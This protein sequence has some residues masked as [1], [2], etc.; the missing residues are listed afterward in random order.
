MEET[1]LFPSG[2][3]TLCGVLYR[4]E[5]Q[6]FWGLV[7][8]PPLFE[9]RKSAQRVMVEAARAFAAAGGAVLRFDYRGCGDSSGDFAAFSCAD[10]RADIGVACRFLAERTPVESLGLL[11]LRLGASLA[12]ETAA[13]HPGLA[14]FLVLWEPLVDGRKY[15]DQELRRKLVNDMVT[16]GRS[17]TTRASLLKD[18]EAGR[19][20]DFD[21]YALSPRL[22]ADLTAIDLLN[23]AWPASNKA[24]LVRISRAGEAGPDLTRLRQTLAAAGT[25]VESIPA[26]EDPFWNLVGL[27]E[28]PTLIRKTRE[29]FLPL[30][31]GPGGEPPPSGR[32]GGARAAESDPRE[33]EACA[34]GCPLDFTVNGETLRGILHEPE[35]AA[36]GPIVVFLHGWAGSRLGPHRM[37]VHFARRLAA[38]GCPSLRFDFRGR[39]DSEGGTMQATIRSMVADAGAAIDAVTDRMPRRKVVLLGICSGCKVAIACAAGDPRV[40]GLALWSAEPMGPMRASAAVGGKS[41]QALRAYGRKLLRLETWRKLLTLSVNVRLVGKAV[42]GREQAGRDEIR[43][44]TRWLAQLRDYTGPALLVYG[45]NDPETRVAKPGY[46]TLFQ[47]ANIPHEVHE[48]AGANHSFYSLARERD[49]MEVTEQWLRLNFKFGADATGRP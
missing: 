35:G 16:F 32:P 21:G 11:G 2:A 20:I 7:M 22:A 8:C 47:K 9:E 31:P 23:S 24:L 44:E 38:A 10:W 13:A 42:A 33:D 29:W 5:R 40:G 34:P 14:R 4:P 36:P 19:T 25:A 39:G 1:V 26:E 18:L 15:L 37:F 49:V 3:E 28:S 46:T 6:A 45:A 12:L 27:V 41:A 43:D 17:Q 30:G 48:L